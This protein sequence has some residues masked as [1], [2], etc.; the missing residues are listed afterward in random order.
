[1]REKETLGGG[2]KEVFGKRLGRNLGGKG[3]RRRRKRLHVAGGEWEW[4]A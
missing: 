1:M 2:Q 3:G 4:R